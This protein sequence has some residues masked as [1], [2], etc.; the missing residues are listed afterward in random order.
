LTDAAAAA[1]A[2]AA[3]AAAAT[4]AASAARRSRSALLTYVNVGAAEGADGKAGVCA[5]GT[6]PAAADAA[7]ARAA[8]ARASA[9]ASAAAAMRSIRNASSTSLLVDGSI[10]SKKN[11]RA[12]QAV[13]KSSS[14]EMNELNECRFFYSQCFNF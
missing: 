5:G 1:A 8:A 10:I 7:T 4:A 3:S 9:R 12:R 11:Y 6:P 13:I 14:F 2:A